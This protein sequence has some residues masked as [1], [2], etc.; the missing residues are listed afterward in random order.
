[1]KTKLKFGYPIFLLTLG[2]NLILPTFVTCSSIKVSP[3]LF[4]NFVRIILKGEMCCVLHHV[5]D[6][7]IA[8]EDVW[9]DSFG[10]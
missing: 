9:I 1:M 3:E 6:G 10:T 5:D 8:E 2:R 7:G 4:V